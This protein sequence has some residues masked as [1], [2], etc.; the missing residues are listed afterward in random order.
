MNHEYVAYQKTYFALVFHISDLFSD[1]IKTH[2][3]LSE[4]KIAFCQKELLGDY[5]KAIKELGLDTKVICFDDGEYSMKK[6]IEQYD[7][8]S[9]ED[10]FT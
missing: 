5:L 10:E 8:K 6:F 7:D 4:P 2:F 9:K 3:S 1:E